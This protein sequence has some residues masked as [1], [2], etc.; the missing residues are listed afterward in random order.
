MKTLHCVL[1]TLSAVIIA[2]CSVLLL[3]DLAGASTTDRVTRVIDG[4]TIVVNGHET[5]RLMGVDTPETVKPFTPVQCGGPEA[6][7]FVKRLT[8]KSVTL[9]RIKADYYGRTLAYVSYN[10]KDL[11][12]SLLKRGLAKEYT[13]KGQWYA[14]HDAYK[15]A[16]THAVVTSRGV[17]G[18]C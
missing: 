11:G 3:G 12:L 14:K 16:E 8:H 6:S 17:W 15:Q 13:F 1:R 7:R 2:L 10:G 5:V 4:D 18:H 9:T